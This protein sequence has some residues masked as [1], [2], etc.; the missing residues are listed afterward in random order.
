MLGSLIENIQLQQ[1]WLMTTLMGKII[2]IVLTSGLFPNRKMYIYTRR[3]LNIIKAFK[4][5]EM[6]KKNCPKRYGYM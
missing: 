5:Y 1:L 2:F 3:T 4:E 6:K